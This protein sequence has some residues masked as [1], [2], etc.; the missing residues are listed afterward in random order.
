M[1]TVAPMTTQVLPTSLEKIVVTLEL[2]I[3]VG[4]RA[5][6]VAL[7]VNIIGVSFVNSL[8]L[9]ETGFRL[10]KEAKGK[11]KIGMPVQVKKLMQMLADVITHVFVEMP[12]KILAMKKAP[13]M[14]LVYLM[15]TSVANIR[16]QM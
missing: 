10:T 2:Q 15:A 5:T 4:V 13:A 3:F 12:T 16:K 6:L 7:M 11:H 1:I 8:N 14:M 9:P